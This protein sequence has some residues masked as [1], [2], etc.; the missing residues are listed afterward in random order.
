M[1]EL[2]HVNVEFEE[3]QLVSIA[4]KWTALSDVENLRMLAGL[5]SINGELD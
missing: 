5:K 1:S 2:P 4:Q 3:L